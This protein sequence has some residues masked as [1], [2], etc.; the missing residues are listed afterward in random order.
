MVARPKDEL[1]LRALGSDLVYRAPAPESTGNA[2]KQ[3]GSHAA[4][5][6]A[7][8]GAKRLG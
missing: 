1:V 2:R 6:I 5:T 4:P 3:A 8:D 7:L